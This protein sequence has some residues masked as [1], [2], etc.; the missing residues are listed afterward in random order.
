MSVIT[1]KQLAEDVDIPVDLLLSQL[2][3]A[4][5]KQSKDEDQVSEAEK[6]QLLAHLRKSHGKSEVAAGGSGRKITL[7][8]KS[9]S[10]LRQPAAAGRTPVRG[11]AARTGKTVSVEVRRKRVVVKTATEQERERLISE[12]EAAKKA[13]AEQDEQKKKVAA[14]AEARRNAET[15]K[16]IN[17]FLVTLDS[18]SSP[19]RVAWYPRLLMTPMI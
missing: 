5:L 14:E 11:T 9:V 10:E 15:A 12:A 17:S 3:K 6:A 13:L 19:V 8:R 4:G 18:N 7:K 2:A 1:V 16:R